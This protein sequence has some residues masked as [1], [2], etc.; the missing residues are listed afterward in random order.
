MAWELA[1]EEYGVKTIAYS[2]TGHKQHSK[3]QLKLTQEELDEG[4]DHVIIAAK[5]LRR[6]AYYLTPY[7]QNLLSRNWFQVKNS[8]AIFPV[9][10]FVENS[11]HTKVAG[12]TGW[13]VQMAMD[14]NKPIYLFEQN[15]ESWYVYDYELN[16]FF[17]CLEQPIPT[18]TP[19]FAGIGTRTINDAGIMAIQQIYEQTFRG[20]V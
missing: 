20:T 11:H 7:V 19:N 9:G 10:M 15:M 8:E 4:F 3:N 13:A 16:A 5:S 18:L 1:G 14:N 2:F 17:A 12:G 6:N